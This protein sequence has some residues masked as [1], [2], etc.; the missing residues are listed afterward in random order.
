[1]K[2]CFLPAFW[3]HKVETITPSIS[4]SCH[5]P[6]DEEYLCSQM[7]STAGHLTFLSKFKRIDKAHEVLLTYYYIKNLLEQ[8]ENVTNAFLWL[9][10]K[11][12]IPRF[13]AEM[14]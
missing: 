7:I 14:S 1:M 4:I 6:S 13:S 5:S 2:Y 11:L 12:W 3:F 10:D 9:Q 8:S